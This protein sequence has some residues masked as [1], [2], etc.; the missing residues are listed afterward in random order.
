[1]YHILNSESKSSLSHNEIIRNVALFIIAG[2]D[3][4]ATA[5]SG[6][7]YFVCTHT[8]VYRRLV[9]EVRGNMVTEDD[10][11]WENIRNLHYLDA[12]VH[13]ALWLFPPST[14][15]QQ[16]VVP[17][18]GATV[19]GYFVPAGTTVAVPPWVLTHSAMHFHEPEAFRPERWLGTDVRYSKDHH[20]ASLPFGTGPR[21]CIGRNLANMEMKLITVKMLW[22]YDIEL[23][24]KSHAKEN[25]AWGSDGKMERMKIFHSMEKPDLWVKLTRAHR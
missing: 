5:L 4:T 20:N 23:D 13:E 2:T 16:R 6:W 21:I 22:N 3:T 18:G 1:M 8:D 25:L 17:Q 9:E 10:I 19:D 15:S 24:N 11:R 12:T 14:A 7:T